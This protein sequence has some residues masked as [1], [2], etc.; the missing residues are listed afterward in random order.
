[1]KKVM[2]NILAL[3]QGLRTLDANQQDTDF[4]KAKRYYGLFSMTPR[5]RTLPHTHATST[6]NDIRKCWM[7]SSNTGALALRNTRP[8]STFSVA[9]SREMGPLAQRRR[10][11]ATTTTTSLSYMGWSLMVVRRGM[12][13]AWCQI[14]RVIVLISHGYHLSWIHYTAKYTILISTTNYQVCLGLCTFFCRSHSGSKATMSS[15]KKSLTLDWF[16][17]VTAKP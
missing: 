10:Q 12:E 1:M 8:C 2:R 6:Y 9:T 7:I 13:A 17:L 15:G 16:C 3:Q 5:V 11:I 4:E 14:L